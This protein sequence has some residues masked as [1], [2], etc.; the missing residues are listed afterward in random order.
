[1]KKLFFYFYAS[2]LLVACSKKDESQTIETIIPD[3]NFEQALI[4]LGYDDILDNIVLTSNIINITS[5]DVSR[6]QISDL[7]GIENFI[8]LQ[9]LYVEVNNLTSL[10]VSKNYNLIN[11]SADRNKL[12]CIN[13]S[14]NQYNEL[15]PDLYSKGVFWSR[16]VGSL[17][18]NSVI[19]NTNCEKPDMNNI[20][21]V[22]STNNNDYRMTGQDSNGAVDDLDVRLNFK[23]G[24]AIYFYINADG[25]NTPHY[26]HIKS[27]PTTG[28]VDQID[29]PTGTYKGEIIWKPLES[30]T[31]Y[32]QCR[33]HNGHGGEI[34]IS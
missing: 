1:M 22:T 20:I 5:L 16:A 31:Y 32:Y 9:E 13:L 4:D 17:N 19:F 12:T 14:K 8:S 26:F 34:I 27:S 23:K 30:G 2:L 10:D 24:D 33:N 29:I 15:L 28:L 6:K 18:Y 11:L 7:T 21:Y 3:D 25:N